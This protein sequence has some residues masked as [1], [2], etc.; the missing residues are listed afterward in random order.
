MNPWISLANNLQY[1]SI[2]RE[3]GWQIRFRWIQRPGN[4]LYIVYT[5]NWHDEIGVPQR[6]FSTID[7]RLATKLV[8]TLRF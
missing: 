4:D 3:L 5:H 7:N 2:S 1:D 6:R 8:Y